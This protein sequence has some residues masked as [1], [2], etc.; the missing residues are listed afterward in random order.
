MKSTKIGLG[1]GVGG[2]LGSAISIED[3]IQVVISRGFAHR[4]DF[5]NIA[6]ENN[7][8]EMIEDPIQR[9][10]ENKGNIQKKVN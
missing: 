4:N 7:L 3:K 8:R 5:S 9:I 2:L 6:K 10:Q 1:I